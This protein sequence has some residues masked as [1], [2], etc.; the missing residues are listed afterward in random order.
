MDGSTIQCGKSLLWTCSQE[1]KFLSLT[2]HT[3]LDQTLN[4]LR[5]GIVKTFNLHAISNQQKWRRTPQISSGFMGN[6]EPN[7]QWLPYLISIVVFNS[8]FV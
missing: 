3:N 5:S 4:L 1:M 7:C 8:D 2:R 6:V